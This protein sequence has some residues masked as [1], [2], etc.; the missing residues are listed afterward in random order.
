[1]KILDLDL[2]LAFEITRDFVLNKIVHCGSRRGGN[3]GMYVIIQAHAIFF[4]KQFLQSREKASC[5]SFYK[6]LV[7]LAV[8]SPTPG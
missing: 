1:M 7:F 8:A 3:W 5:I 2:H 6:M 4:S